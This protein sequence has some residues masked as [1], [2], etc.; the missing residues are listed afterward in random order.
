MQRGALGGE[1]A[2][3]DR[4]GRELDDI[5]P[6]RGGGGPGEHKVEISA[7]RLTAPHRHRLRQGRE[8]RETGA[9]AHRPGRH[10][11]DPV[12]AVLISHG[13]EERVLHRDPDVVEVVPAGGVEHAALNG[14]AGGCLRGKDGSQDGR[15]EDAEEA[16]VG[17]EARQVFHSEVVRTRMT[18][19]NGTTETVRPRWAS[20]DGYLAGRLV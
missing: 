17:R 14:A 11:G 6:G 16:V 19:Q 4:E 5:R 20:A 15:R 3:L 9:D 13:L 1:F 7:D 18:G 2:L 8:T 10:P 12:F